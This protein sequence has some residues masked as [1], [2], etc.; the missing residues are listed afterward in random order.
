MPFVKSATV[1]LPRAAVEI[2][3]FF[4]WSHPGIAVKACIQQYPGEPGHEDDITT[5]AGCKVFPEEQLQKHYEKSGP[6]IYV[7]TSINPTAGEIELEV[8]PDWVK[9]AKA[10]K[11][12]RVKRGTRK[13]AIPGL[14]IFE[15][16]ANQN[17]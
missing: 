3:N 13:S 10:D 15:S 2:I 6:P 4:R 9:L 7:I 17:K 14:S 11:D 8:H 12:Q 16:G 1:K 5:L